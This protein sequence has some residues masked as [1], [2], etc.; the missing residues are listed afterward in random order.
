MGTASKLSVTELTPQ[1]KEALIY[2]KQYEN[3]IVK[4]QAC[5]RGFLAIKQKFVKRPAKKSSR[6][7]NDKKKDEN[8]GEIEAKLSHRSGGGR[9]KGGGM[10]ERQGPNSYRNGLVF[11]KALSSLPD[12]SSFAT[13]ETEKQLGPFIF[14]LDDKKLFQIEIITRGP[15]ELDNGAIY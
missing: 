10:A 7:L 14:D 1:L 9:F 11:A 2:A 13:R 15:Y 8:G 5:V 3:K 4:I 12:Y 6:K